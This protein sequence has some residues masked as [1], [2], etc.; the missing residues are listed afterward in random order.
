MRAAVCRAYGPPESLV[1]EEADDP[2]AGPGEVVVAV[3]AA[4]VNFPD[5]LLIAD[6]YQLSV[7]VP[8]T[9]G[10]EFAGE[11]IEAGDDVDA[12]AVGD[13][14]CGTTFHGAFAERV[15]VA[16]AA[17]RPIPDGVADD[18]AAAFFVTHATAWHAL[19][20]VAELRAGERLLVTGAA[21]GVGS[22]AVAL[23]VV[24]GAEVVA[25]ASGAEK[26]AACADAGASVLI[27]SGRDDVRDQ[28]RELVPDGVD[29]VVDVVGGAVAEPALRACRW[30]ARFVTIGFASGDIPAIPLNLV[31]LKGVT[32]MGLEMRGFGENRPDDLARDRAEL[33]SMLAEGRVRPVIGARVS[34][35]DV[36]VGLRLLADRR[37]HGKVV[38]VP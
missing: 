24:A 2:V 4:A 21:G 10:S 16:A 33:D 27:D 18:T 8:F 1:V 15:V 23:G 17:V 20:S 30:G 29:V 31:L 34:L 14:V 9:P 25:V 12:V 36:A 32:V 7:P 37:V 22:A 6:R 38:V 26:L 19:R 11:V 28:L 13:R 35:D 3:R 5:L